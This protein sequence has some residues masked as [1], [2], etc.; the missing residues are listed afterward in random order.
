M[1]IVWL[2]RAQ[3]ELVHIYEYITAEDPQVAL[4][5]VRRIHTAVADLRDTPGIGRPGRLS[6][7]RELVVTGMPFIIPYRVRDGVIEILS[8]IHTARKWPDSL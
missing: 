4:K 6:G 1:N 5:I 3:R 2:A 8:I 7:T